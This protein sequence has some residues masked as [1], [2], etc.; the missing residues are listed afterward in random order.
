MDNW[1]AYLLNLFG[2]DGYFYGD[3]DGDGI[4]DCPPNNPATPNYVDTT[5]LPKPYFA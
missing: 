4:L 5:A 1:P 3:T 2:C